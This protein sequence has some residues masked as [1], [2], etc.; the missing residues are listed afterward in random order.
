MNTINGTEWDKCG[1][2]II[3]YHANDDFPLWLSADDL[4]EVLEGLEG[5]SD[6]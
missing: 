2:A 1:N 6:D 5:H 3:I 4:R